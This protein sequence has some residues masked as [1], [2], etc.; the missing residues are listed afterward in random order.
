M[1]SRADVVI[2]GAGG[3]GGIVA[4]ELAEAGMSVVQL[5]KGRWFTPA[6]AVHDELSS[7]KNIPRT[8]TKLE[9]LEENPRS[10]RRDENSPTRVAPIGWNAFGVGG[11]TMWY[12]A[13]SWRFHE[14]HFRMKSTYGRPEG[15]TL[16]DWPLT[17]DDL[18]PHYEKAEYELGVSG[19]AGADPFGPPRK[20]PDPVPPLPTNPQGELFAKA[21]RKLGLHPFPPPFA[22]ITENYRGR[23]GCVRCPFCIGFVCEVDAKSSTAVTVIPVARTTGNY[24]LKTKCVV[25][26][27]VTDDRGQVVGVSYFDEDERHN[28]QPAHIVIVSANAGESARILLNSRSKH[29][30]NGLANSSDQVGRNLMTHIGANSFGIFDFDIPHEWGPGPSMAVNDFAEGTLGGGHIYNFYVHHPIRFTRSRPPGA[31]RWGKA[32]KDFQRQYFR[33]FMHLNSDVADMP[34]E[35]NRVEIDR[36]LRDGWGI[37]ALRIT[38]KFLPID[39]EHS[40]FVSARQR[41]ILEAA[42]AN[43]IWSAPAGGGGYL[44]QHQCGT[45]RMGTDPKVSVLNRYCQTHEI[46]NLFVID[47]S[48][49]V[50]FPGH[51][52]TLTAQAIAY[53]ASDYIKREWRSGALRQ[54]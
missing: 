48:C 20:K 17:Y 45:C 27:V 52:P 54:A 28:F 15:T 14:E 47:T 1:T 16:D 53:W 31:P 3:A 19:L 33:R 5:D 50:S 46:D 11:G 34:A 49:F 35:Y 23:I 44:G 37:P 39:I 10:F 21:A 18:E 2:V 26:R 40:K 36:D 25:D 9:G 32:H 4:K 13:A 22:I 12:G 6:D 41:E 51:N 38:R 8:I 29:W 42:G 43:E 24:T 30:P 7:D